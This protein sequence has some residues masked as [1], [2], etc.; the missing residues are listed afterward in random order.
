[1]LVKVYLNDFTF[2]VLC[3]VQ[4]ICKMDTFT[5]NLY[6]EHVF[7][8]TTGNLTVGEY[9]TYRIP[10][11][12]PTGVFNN[13]KVVDTL[14]NGFQYTG[15]YFVNTTNFSGVI[16]NPIVTVSGQSI[17]FLFSGLTN[18]TASNNPF[19]IDLQALVLN[20]TI[21]NATVPTKTNTAS[22]NW[23][24]NTAGAFTATKTATIVEPKLSVSKAVTPTTVDGGDK[25]T[26]TLNVTNNGGSPAYNVN[27]TDTLN[28]TLFDL[29]TF[30]YTP[31]TGFNI[32]LIGNTVNIVAGDDTTVINPGQTIQFI[33]TLNAMKDVPSNSSFINNATIQSFRSLPS[34]Y[35]ESRVYPAVNS[36]NVTISTV[37]PSVS[38]TIN[39]TSEPDSTGTNVMC[40][41]VRMILLSIQLQLQQESV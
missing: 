24:E 26:V 41:Q 37:T 32:S 21:N 23:D 38:K 34:S 35:T 36:N 14:P 16:S 33:F 7:H 3:L 22:L 13:I 39:S 17:T 18:S 1:M 31:V 12:M 6:V 29:T 8:G 9:V 11:T 19:Y 28:S 4:N 20:Q 40:T 5:F 30:N 15:F 25:M 10:V 27:L 2:N